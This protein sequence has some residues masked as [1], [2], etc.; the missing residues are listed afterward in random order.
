MLMYNVEDEAPDFAEFPA[1]ILTGRIRLSGPGLDDQF[2][3][4]AVLLL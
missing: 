1:Y 4:I 2:V 3:Q